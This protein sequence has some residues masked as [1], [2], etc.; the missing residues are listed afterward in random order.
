MQP[1]MRSLRAYDRMVMKIRIPFDKPNDVPIIL[2]V[3]SIV[4]I[5]LGHCHSAYG[6][7]RVFIFRPTE[8]TTKQ[9][10]TVNVSRSIVIKYGLELRPHS[11]SRFIA[12]DSQSVRLRP[13]LKTSEGNA[14]GFVIV[15]LDQPVLDVVI[16]PKFMSKL[17]SSVEKNL[18]AKQVMEQEANLGVEFTREHGKLK[19]LRVTLN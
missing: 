11:K 19:I 12:L 8:V 10:G 2:G 16:T 13:T 14:V 17:R 5:L 9:I 18:S 7:S 15:T 3:A 4:I 6:D 1:L